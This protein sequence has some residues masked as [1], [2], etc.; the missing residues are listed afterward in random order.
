LLVG[1]LPNSL[2]TSRI[3]VEQYANEL[4][5]RVQN[6]TY[7]GGGEPWISIAHYVHI[8]VTRGRREVKKIYAHRHTRIAKNLNKGSPEHISDT[9]TAEDVDR[10]LEQEPP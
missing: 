9:N 8:D 2:K 6:I 5:P 10:T 3:C 1:I 4:C 7:N